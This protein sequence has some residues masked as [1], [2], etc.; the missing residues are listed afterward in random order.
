MPYSNIIYP[1]SLSYSFQRYSRFCV[2]ILT[3]IITIEHHLVSSSLPNLHSIENLN[4][5][6]R[7]EDIKERKTSSSFVL[8]GL[9]NKLIF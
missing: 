6:G 4:I 2:L 8:K 5:S 7:E 9:V 3:I 1:I